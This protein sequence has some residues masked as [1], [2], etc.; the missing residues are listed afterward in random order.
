MQLGRLIE[1]NKGNNVEKFVE[2][3]EEATWG[4]SKWSAA[5]FQYTLTALNCHT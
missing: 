5:W 4:K 1:Y 3:C 2:N